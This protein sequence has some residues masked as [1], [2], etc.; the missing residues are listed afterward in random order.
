MKAP[1]YKTF[2]E[3]ADELAKK[4][5]GKS[6]RPFRDDYLKKLL[7]DYWTG[8]FESDTGLGPAFTLDRILSGTIEPFTRDYTWNRLS[9]IGDLPHEIRDLPE[10]SKP[11]WGA[12]SHPVWDALAAMNVE[13]FSRKA[14]ENVLEELC[15]SEGDAREWIAENPTQSGLTADARS[16]GGSRSMQNPWLLEA[17]QRIVDMLD[18]D[19]IP[20]TSTAIW[21]W[22]CEN[23]LKDEHYEFDPLIL[24]CDLL[25]VVGDELNFSDQQGNPHSRKRRSLERYM[26]R[27]RAHQD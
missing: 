2:G 1:G 25:Y 22:L 4:R 14:K 20:P 5:H 18:K 21:T 3:I 19:G 24:G 27:P 8:R 23:A 11:A 17:I 16:R 9:Y 12:L 13:D 6:W 15:L 26:P 10:H 7:H